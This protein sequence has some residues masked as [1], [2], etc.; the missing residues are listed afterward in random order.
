MNDKQELEKFIHTHFGYCFYSLGAQPVIY[1]LYVYPEY[2]RQGNSRVLLQMAISEIR[3]SDYKG[4]I[5]VQAVP[6]E[7]SI[8]PA[9]LIQY[10]NSLELVVMDSCKTK[11]AN[12]NG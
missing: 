11:E 12:Q 4:K 7:N 6:K 9:K 5:C 10:Y 1:N 8:E 2:R 3:R